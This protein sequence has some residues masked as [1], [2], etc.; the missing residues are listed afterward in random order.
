EV[1]AL[2][3]KDGREVVLVSNIDELRGNA[4]SIPEFTTKPFTATQ[5]DSAETARLQRVLAELG[6]PVGAIDGVS[7][8]STTAAI[9]AFQIRMGLTSSGATD[10]ATLETINAT[11]DDIDFK[12]FD[13]A[14][15]YFSQAKLAP[16]IGTDQ[17]KYRHVRIWVKPFYT[18]VYHSRNHLAA[19]LANLIYETSNLKAMQEAGSGD[20]YEGR[21]DL[22]N[23]EPGDGRRFKGRGYA[24]IVGR[25][26]Y[27][28]FG[29][30]VGVDLVR[31]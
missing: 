28:S 27:Q 18:A 31:Q 21:K 26:N 14:L 9:R 25:E 16:V 11:I 5:L 12:T 23:T 13:E 22:G 17:E 1:F 24:E 6:Y 20:Q 19:I 2:L 7:G 30:A 15:A 10:A 8:P 3:S 29:T 4:T